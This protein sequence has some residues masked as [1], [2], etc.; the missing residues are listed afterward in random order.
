MNL[1]LWLKKNNFRADQVQTFLPSPMALATTM[2]HT[3][4]NPLRKIRPQS[5][6]ETVFSARG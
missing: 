5:D 1:A 2:Y 4:Q 3:E 6:G